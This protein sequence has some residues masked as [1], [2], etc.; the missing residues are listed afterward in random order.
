MLYMVISGCRQLLVQLSAMQRTRRKWNILLEGVL[1][2]QRALSPPERGK[3]RGRRRWRR[4]SCSA[5]YHKRGER[6]V[7]SL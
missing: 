2:L 4:G 5:P 6:Y 3:G 7:L 1:P